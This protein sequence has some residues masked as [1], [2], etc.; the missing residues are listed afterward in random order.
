MN[1][2]RITCII[3]PSP[4]PVS[5]FLLDPTQRARSLSQ[6]PEGITFWSQP[7]ILLNLITFCESSVRV[8]PPIARL[9]ETA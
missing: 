2:G 8:S 1:K 4:P 9:E 5:L 7:S 6:N 3:R